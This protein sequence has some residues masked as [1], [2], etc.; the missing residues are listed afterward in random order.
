[1]PVTFALPTPHVVGAYYG[2][3]F[4]GQTFSKLPQEIDCCAPILQIRKLR[5]S[6]VIDRVGVVRK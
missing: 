6:Y 3:L 1:V 4:V 2:H 5:P